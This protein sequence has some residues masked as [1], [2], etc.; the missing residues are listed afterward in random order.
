MVIRLLR[1][2]ITR[3]RPLEIDDI[4][5]GKLVYIAMPKD[6][7]SYW[8]ARR[9]FIPCHREV[10][11]FIDAPGH[12]QAPDTKQRDF[13]TWVENYYP[14]II[15]STTEV[16]RTC[17]ENWTGSPLAENCNPEFILTSFSIPLLTGDSPEWEISY[18]QA[19][20]NHLFTVSMRGIKPV[21]VSID[22]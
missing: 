17:Y 22:G 12:K 7:T 1:R 8:E 11:L 19:A 3:F 4:Y 21:D 14:A 18:E 16:L 13:F 15:I 2:V 5:F 10:E 20:T 6:K 9:W